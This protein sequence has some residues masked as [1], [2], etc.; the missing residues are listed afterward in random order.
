MRQDARESFVV[1]AP[2]PRDI[3]DWELLAEA[4]H[5]LG[6]EEPAVTIIEFGDYQCPVCRS[7]HHDI[8]AVMRRNPDDVAFV[9]RHW[10]LP[11]HT[12]A[13]PAAR[14]AECAGRQQRFWEFH[15]LLYENDNWLGDAMSRFA[16][17]AGVQDIEAFKECV[18][19]SMPVPAIEAD[20]AAAREIGAMGTPTVIVNGTLLASGRDSL[21]LQ[22]LI[23]ETV[24]Q[25]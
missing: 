25:R 23:D 12:Y 9:Y 20:I 14:A 21:S 4:G 17:T 8:K 11:Y 1:P 19:D 7:W 18:A 5:R 16:E 10:P 2:G 24:S 3:Q 13:Y 22:T 15:T 6:P